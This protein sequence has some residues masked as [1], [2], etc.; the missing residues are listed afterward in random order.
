MRFPTPPARSMALAA[1][2]IQEWERYRNTAPRMARYATTDTPYTTQRLSRN[3][4]KAAPV[5][6]T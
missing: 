2:V 3:S 5:F 4:P 1:T 6:S